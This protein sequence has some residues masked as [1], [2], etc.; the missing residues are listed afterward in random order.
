VGVV[1]EVY[2]AGPLVARGYVGLPGLTAERFVAC[3]F[4]PGTGALPA[5]GRGRMYRTGD[6][7]RRTADGS[8][9]S[10]RRADDQVE[11]GGVRVEP[12]EVRGVLTAHPQVTEAAVIAREDTPGARRLVAYVVAVEPDAALSETVRAYA[13]ER[14]PAPMVPSA[15][16]VLDALPLSGNGTLDREALPAPDDPATPPAPGRRELTPQEETLATAFADVLGVP[17]VGPDDDFFRH[18][19]GHSLLAARLVSRIRTVLSVEVP[20][21]LL[22]EAPTVARLAKHIGNQQSARPALRPMRSQE[23]S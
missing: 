23:E 15:V 11:I 8:L 19:G 18:L 21:R 1:G 4:A 20:L 22:F 13:A 14:L 6:R 16:V 5:G 3:P 10:V 7:A 9:V 12:A 17:E 2:V